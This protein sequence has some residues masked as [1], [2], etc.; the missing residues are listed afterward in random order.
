MLKIT[1]EQLVSQYLKGDETALET[2]FQRYLTPIF[3][4]SRR[5]VGNV[6][7]ASDV[8]QESFV[9]AW[10]NLK[11]FD[12]SKKFKSWLFTIAKNTA[13]DWLRKN[14]ALPFS[15]LESE[16]EIFDVADEAPSF[17][18]MLELKQSS[19]ELEYAI[20]DLPT[21]YRK[22]VKLRHHD[23]LSFRGIADHLKEPL[24]TVK[25]RYRRGVI[26]LKKALGDDFE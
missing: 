4:F 18:K 12:I 7:V 5:Y 23:A 9:K 17:L 24:N 16:D 10:K 13:F 20:N 8:T 26:I 19:K 11:R 6:D 1:D 21:H 3:N 22:V 15:A 14:H 25:S 2:L